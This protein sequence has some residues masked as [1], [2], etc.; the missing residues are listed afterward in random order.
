MM[1]RVLLSLCLLSVTLAGLAVVGAAPASAG[2][3]PTRS[4]A[5]FETGDHVRMLSVCARIWISD[6]SPTQS[7]GV[8]EMHTFALVNGHWTDV[9]SQS[10]TVNFAN[11]NTFNVNGDLLRSLTFGADKSSS[12]CRVNGP[13]GKIACG[14]PNAGRVAFYSTAFNGVAQRFETCVSGVSW[15]DDRGQ[16]HFVN[17]GD[18]SSPGHLPLCFFDPPL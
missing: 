18:S 11:F 15:R 12:T 2:L 7:R 16:P 6:P 14:V 8:V 3:S 1:K 13:S 10:I 5:N 4:C 17:S 9:T